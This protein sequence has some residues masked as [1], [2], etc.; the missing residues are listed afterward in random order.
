MA[1]HINIDELI[2]RKKEILEKKKTIPKENIDEIKELVKEY[3][4]IQKKIQ[5]Y[6]DEEYRINKCLSSNKYNKSHKETYN[7]YHKNYQALKKAN[8]VF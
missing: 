7:N 3:D 1:T 4:R 6:S 8:A 2:E 5:Y